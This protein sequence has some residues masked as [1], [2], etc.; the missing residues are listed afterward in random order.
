MNFNGTNGSTPL[1]DLMQVADGSFI[2][3]TTSGGAHGFGT[4]FEVWPDGR[5]KTLHD[6]T[7]GGDGGN[8]HGT[9]AQGSDG[10]LYGMTSVGGSYNYGTIYRLSVPM[11][12]VFQTV[13]KTN[14]SLEVKWSAVVGQSYQLQCK[15]DSAATNWDNLGAVIVATNATIT[16]SDSIVPDGQ[17]FY[18]VLLQ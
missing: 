14:G 9:P 4:V 5:F 17:R 15:T 3:T 7:G 10:N 2:G 11:E 16:A 6:F 8:P 12:P 13:R 18:R 1:T